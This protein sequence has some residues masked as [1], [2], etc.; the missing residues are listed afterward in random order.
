[1]QDDDQ[2]ERYATDEELLM[3]KEFGQAIIKLV[4]ELGI[5]PHVLIATMAE[6]LGL[7]INRAFDPVDTLETILKQVVQSAEEWDD[8]DEEYYCDH[9]QHKTIQ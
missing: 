9:P 7:Y 2:A 5:P 6:L 3:I 1:M 4:H 8:D